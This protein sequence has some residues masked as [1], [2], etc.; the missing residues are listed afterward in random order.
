M[1]D[2]SKQKVGT[3][4]IGVAKSVDF[5]ALMQA[6]LV[7]VFNEREADRRRAALRE[8]YTED[9]TLYDPETVATGREAISAA[10]DSLL[11]SLPPDFVFTP[12][13]HA[14]GHN[15]VARLFWRAGPPDGAV[16][17]TGTDVAHIE[18][19]RIKSLYVF[20]DPAPR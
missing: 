16:A 3:R 12:A 14:V 2:N 18:D 1:A 19:G 11:A 4:D 10:I 15:C 6:N 8:L 20:V 9:A 17:V 7:H 5:D 13:G